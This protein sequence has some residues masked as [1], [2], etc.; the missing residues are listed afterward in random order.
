M[1]GCKDTRCG[2]MRKEREEKKSSKGKQQS[3]T[4]VGK[5]AC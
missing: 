2:I 5:P 3:Q 4:A 1:D